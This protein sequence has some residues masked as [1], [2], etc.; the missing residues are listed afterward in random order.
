MM[1]NVITLEGMIGRYEISGKNKKVQATINAD[2]FEFTFEQVM[3]LC[4][5]FR[6]LARNL[7]SVENVG[8][9]MW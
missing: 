3:G 5:E 9:E 8:C 6:A 1:D 2:E 4:D 7:G